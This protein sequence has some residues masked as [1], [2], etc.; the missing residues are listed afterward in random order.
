ME[1][2]FEVDYDVM[3]KLASQYLM[4][5]YRMLADNLK[6][7]IEKIDVY[8]FTLTEFQN[9]TD[10]LRYLMAMEVVMEYCIGF[11]WREKFKE[12]CK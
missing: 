6:K 5:N 11:D 7:Y 10:D 1:I 8:D 2:K 12:F 3:D 9:Y 4:D